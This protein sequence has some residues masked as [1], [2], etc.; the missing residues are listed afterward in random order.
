VCQ[1]V[2]N[3]LDWAFAMVE[4]DEVKPGDFGVGSCVLEAKDVD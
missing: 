1:S 2:E 4:V 3:D